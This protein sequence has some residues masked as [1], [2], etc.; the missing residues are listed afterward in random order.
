MKKRQKFKELKEETDQKNYI[1][2]Q[3]KKVILENKG[4]QYNE[5]VHKQQMLKRNEKEKNWTTTKV[6]DDIK[7]MYTPI[8]L[9]SRIL[10]SQT[11]KKLAHS[12]Y[13]TINPIITC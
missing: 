10:L 11:Y 1:S 4:Q 3:R 6:T 7:V 8:P 5:M 9:L 13:S 12:Y 2:W